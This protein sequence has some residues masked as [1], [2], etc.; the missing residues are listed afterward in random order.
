MRRR[1]PDQAMHGGNVL[2]M[3]QD[4]HLRGLREATEQIERAKQAREDLV[5]AAAEDDVPRKTI[6][7][8]I[9]MS[10]GMVYNMRLAALARRRES[11]SG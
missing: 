3:D 6:A 11:G 2:Q 7:E 10:E 5:L 4:A 8:A 1:T 9:G